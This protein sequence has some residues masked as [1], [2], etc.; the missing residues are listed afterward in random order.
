MTRCALVEKILV[1]LLLSALLLIIPAG[2]SGIAGATEETPAEIGARL[3]AKYI[4]IKS[5]TFDFTQYTSGQLAGRGGSGSGTA[6]FLKTGKQAKMLWDYNSPSKQVILSNGTTLSMYF[7][8]QKQMIITPADS[9]QQD[10]TYSFF[11]GAGNLENDFLI[12]SPD[13]DVGETETDRNSFKIIKLIPRTPR[14]QVKMIHIWVTADSLIQRM[15]IK[16]YFDTI[17]VLNFTNMKVDSLV[18]D[19]KQSL[20]A[21]F[22]FTPPKGTEIIHQ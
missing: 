7:A 6:Y 8:K 21:L 11:S 19:S 1:P 22:S 3:Q 2:P 10:V 20:N 13:P 5:L 9:L 18:R 14:S 17:T 4:Q 15:E 12:R 16:D